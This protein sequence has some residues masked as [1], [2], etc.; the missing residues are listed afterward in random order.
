MILNAV[1]I[2]HF[3]SRGFLVI[4]NPTDEKTMAELDRLQREIEPAW[5]KM[6]F[7][8]GVHPLA[9]QMLMAGEPVLKMV[10]DPILIDLATEILGVE[11][12][13]IS[14]FGMGDTASTVGGER[15][16]VAWHADA[17]GGVDQVAIRI[18]LDRHDGDN[19]PLR[20]LP[21]SHKWP[22]ERVQEELFEIEMASCPD[23]VPPELFYARHPQE[24]EVKL[25]PRIMLMW[26][27][28]TWHATGKKTSTSLRRA[29]TWHY[30]APGNGNPFQNAV[31]HVLD[32]VWQEW[33][34]ERKRLWGLPGSDAAV[35]P[36]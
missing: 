1:Q 8:E 2:E 30:F 32:G 33:S 9:C 26:T 29:M 20:I 36:A 3:H 18:G 6:D 5:E 11:S 25:D 17:F 16:Q 13:V 28:N 21:G 24:I 4:P 27:P 19:A 34:E 35:G 10:E 31:L 23:V 7:P 15:K 22:Y 12:V 14:A